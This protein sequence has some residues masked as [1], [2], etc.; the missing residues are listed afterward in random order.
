MNIRLTACQ[1]VQSTSQ[2]I[3]LYRG[4]VKRFIYGFLYMYKLLVY[5]KMRKKHATLHSIEIPFLL[6]LKSN[7]ANG[8]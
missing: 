1:R 5:L 7:F 2:N 3:L 8:L 6:L 4:V